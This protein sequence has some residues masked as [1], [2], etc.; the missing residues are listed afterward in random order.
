[1]V[2]VATAATADVP[3]QLFAI[4]TV[5]ASATVSVKSQQ[6]GQIQKSD[7]KEGE[8][9]KA[10]DLLFTIDA[11]PFEAALLQAQANQARD[12]ALLVRAIADLQRAEELRKTDSIAQSALD[13]FRASVDSMR[14]TIA[15]DQAAVANAAVQREYCFI[16]A[17]IDGRIGTL[18]VDAGNIVKDVEAV[19][20]VI[21]RLKPV[22]VDFSLPEQHLPE[23]RARMAGGKLGVTA[24]PPQHAEIKAGGEL[25]L[26]NNEVDVKTGTI[27]LRATFANEN[28]TL[29]PGQFVNV[30]L[31]LQTK[32]NAVIVPTEAIQVGQMGNFIFVAKADSTAELRPVTLGTES[33]GNVVIEKGVTAGERVVTSGMLRL[34]NGAKFELRGAGPAKKSP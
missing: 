25:S 23:I 13:Q 21:N 1:M 10:G 29:W 31:T 15:A 9:V 14:A 8:E 20:A 5:K 27:M 33:D 12:E 24:S 17:P 30:A 34:Q 22:Y 19:L 4:G 26:V 2:T 32:T 18:L 11:R 28:E 16:R 3:A 7:F 6:K